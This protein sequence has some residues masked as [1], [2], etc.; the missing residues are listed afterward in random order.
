MLRQRFQIVCVMLFLGLPMLCQSVGI[1]AEGPDADE[2][3]RVEAIAKRKK[4][5]D[6]EPE[7]GLG[8]GQREQASGDAA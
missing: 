7:Q 6:L 2:R 3:R 1:A 5:E 4:A 8:S